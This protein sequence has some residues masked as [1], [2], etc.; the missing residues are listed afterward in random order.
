MFRGKKYKKAAELINNEL[1]YSVPDAVEL[2]E[3]TNTVKFDPSV[4]VHFNLISQRKKTSI[5]LI[6]W[7]FYM[8]V[9]QI[10]LHAPVQNAEITCLEEFDRENKRTTC[11]FHF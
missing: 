5:S 10:P 4:E 9:L 3:K 11:S 7:S 8:N 1:G 6:Q 2:L